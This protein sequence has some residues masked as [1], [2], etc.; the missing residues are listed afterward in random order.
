MGM[1]S[2]FVECRDSD[3][4]WKSFERFDVQRNLS[5]FHVLGCAG[6]DRYATTSNGEVLP[7]LSSDS[8]LPPDASPSIVHAWSG[9]VD[10]EAEWRWMSG[11]A[12]AQG[13]W[14]HQ[15]SRQQV[16]GPI[17]FR[18]FQENGQPP[19][20]FTEYTSAKAHELTQ[21][22]FQKISLEEM[23]LLIERD[24][25]ILDDARQMRGRVYTVIE[26]K[27]ALADEFEIRPLLQRLREL[28]DRES[29]VFMRVEI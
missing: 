5:L 25:S 24:S 27:I 9:E 26:S 3:H 6:F 19:A 29:R 18:R 22:G 23:A 10:S 21:R 11:S 20:W 2:F 4:T 1:A 7:Q 12:F 8:R 17:D 15:I 14:Q 28:G 16:A 13:P